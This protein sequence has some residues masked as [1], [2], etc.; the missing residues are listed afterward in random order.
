MDL[1]IKVFFANEKFDVLAE[2][3]YNISA[4]VCTNKE[5]IKT[6]FIIMD[7]SKT[8]YCSEEISLEPQVW[9]S[10]SFS[11]IPDKNYSDVKIRI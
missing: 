1:H 6:R 5:N 8:V 10:M 4:D 11:W 9:N 7:G 3:G 2:N